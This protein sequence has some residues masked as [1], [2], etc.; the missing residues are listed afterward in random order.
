MPAR[1]KDKRRALTEEELNEIK[2]RLLLRK[3]ELWKEIMEDIEEGAGEEHQNLVQLVRDHGDDALEELRESTLFS[4]I[5]LKHQELQSIE[6]A[7]NRIEKGAY[8]R[9]QSCGGWIQPARLQV[10]PHVVRCRNCQEKLEKTS[11]I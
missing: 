2:N 8:G 4:L 11:S 7:L 9:C 1:D 6:Q 3:E 5:E 10:M